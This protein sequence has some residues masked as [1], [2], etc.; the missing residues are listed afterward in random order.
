MDLLKDLM[1][2]KKPLHKIPVPTG[3]VCE[4]NA[5]ESVDDQNYNLEEEVVESTTQ[6]AQQ[7]QKKEEALYATANIPQQVSELS[8][9]DTTE[10]LLSTRGRIDVHQIK[11]D[12]IKQVFSKYKFDKHT[13]DS[14]I[15]DNY[16]EQILGLV[17]TNEVVIIQ[18]PTGCG[19]TTRVPQFILDQCKLKEKPVNIV[20]TQPRRIAAISV[21]KRVCE[22]REWP[23]GGICAYQVGLESTRSSDTLLNYV[24]TG[25]L[26]QKLIYDK[27]LHFYTHIIVDEVHERTQDLDFLL[28]VIRRFLFT[29]SSTT[30]VILMSATFDTEEFANYFKNFHSDKN[31]PAPVVFIEKTYKFNTQ[32]FYADQLQLIGKVPSFHLE[33]PKIDSSLYDMFV[34]LIRACDRLDQIDPLTSK[35]KIGHVLVFLPGIYEIEEAH[36]RLINKW[37]K[38]KEEGKNKV[39]W[40]ILPLHSS[41]TTE[42]QRRVF[43]P[44]PPGQ[45]KIILST[46][47]AESSITVPDITFVV[48]FCLTKTLTMDS[49]T[50]YQGLELQWASRINCIQRAGRVGRVSDG[51]VYRLV[52]NS[53][54]ERCLPKIETPEILRSSL[55]ILV[56]RSKILEMDE[57]PKAILALT[58]NPPDLKNIDN[59]VLYL[60][61]IGALT[62][63][64]HG[65]KMVSDGDLTFMG[66]VMAFLPLDVHLS[67]F[68]LLGY[69]FSCLDQVIIMATGCA[70]NIFK[71]PF[72]ERLKAYTNRLQWAD[73][74]ASDLVSYLHLYEVWQRKKR[75][76]MSVKDEKEWCAKNFVSQRS[77]REWSILLKEV[78]ERLDRMHIRNER[79][80]NIALSRGE[81]AMFLK[82]VTCGGFYPNYFK[83]SCDGGQVDERTAV[84]TLGGRDPFNTVYFTGFGIDQPRQLYANSIKN[85]LKDCAKDM[86]VSFDNSS[87]VY[88]QFISPHTVDT[89]TIEGQQFVAQMPGKIHSEVYRSIRHRQLKLP[90]IVTT[91]NSDAAWKLAKQLGIENRTS[92]KLKKDLNNSSQESAHNS[93]V[94]PALTVQYIWLTVSYRIDASHF[95]AQHCNTTTESVI[96]SIQNILNN[97][98][99]NLLRADQN[100]VKV[101]QLYAALFLEDNM[102]YRCKVT[103]LY[104][105]G[106][107]QTTLA[108]VLF[109]DYGNTELKS[110]HDLFVLPNVPV[111]RLPSQAFECVLSEIQPSIVLN[112]RALWSEEANLKFDKYTL[113]KK[114]CGK[115]FSVVNGTVYLQVYKNLAKATDF[116]TSL[117]AALIV[118]GYAQSAEESFL[119][120]ENHLKREQVANFPH[121]IYTLEEDK[122][123]VDNMLNIELPDN[124]CINP[125]HLKGPYSPL[126]MQIFSVVASGINKQVCIEGTSV[127]SV[128]LDTHP[129]DPHERLIV[130][131][132]VGQNVS[133]TLLT[134]RHT[135][136]MPNIHG[137][138]MLMSLLFCPAMEPK[139]TSDGTR[140]GAILCGLGTF[141]SHPLFPSH[142]VCLTLDT[143][144]SE[145]DVYQI[146]TL[147]Y[148]MNRA[149][150]AMECNFNDI[151]SVSS[152]T[153][154]QKEIRQS[155]MTL[156][157]TKR[158]SVERIYLKN[159]NVWGKSLYDGDLLVPEDTHRVIKTPIWPL[160]WTVKLNSVNEE[161]IA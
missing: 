16:R 141:D 120:K 59:S 123:E 20:V 157:Q 36:D 17:N 52:T 106:K 132:H 86:H 87:K 47:I 113:G 12:E 34:V 21:A 51:R 114:L 118:Q 128:L 80:T 159:A 43:L 39:N 69:I 160:H 82:V 144:L 23:L 35:P 88:V 28:L 19:K 91:M 121:N 61:E 156:L 111:L 108:Q 75:M 66:R 56:L 4:Y 8:T 10:D 94:I 151:P 73:S 115:V 64:C 30:K 6:Y 15:I 98:E 77:L 22:E 161:E 54:Y 158:K 105:F 126:E 92:L 103:S 74:S 96:N 130:A 142:D 2:V 138:P 127:N 1:N 57:S 65:V 26:L 60:K 104:P 153:E 131:A 110:T 107:Q 146:N 95:W 27:N 85:V 136:I 71:S 49:S 50:Q 18:G 149:I 129:Q 14:L 117:N 40:Q 134:L 3:V 7:Y 109:I 125:V 89:I 29:N 53:F 41:I 99:C 25:V 116:K 78:K 124:E 139:P 154:C 44:P 42:E 101:G 45:R 145:Q 100:N 68:I 62:V 37:K 152:I 55:N 102:F 148:W 76:N 143:E 32:T 97:K 11:N 72:K 137:F 155:L 83:R 81:N 122:T 67:K 147:R 90:N 133:S 140:I 38:D 112:P 24:T 93:S 150:D 79:S 33:E 135:T 48:D 63:T 5:L 13:Q 9:V 46:N 58:M 119:S 31:L 84:K 70:M